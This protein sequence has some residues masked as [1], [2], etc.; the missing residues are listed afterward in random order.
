[1]DPDATLQAI[2]DLTEDYAKAPDA[3]GAD[4]L[5]TLVERI[6]ALDAWITDGGFLP[7]DWSE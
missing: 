7:N 3:F 6:D 4:N 5:N 2:R 1:M